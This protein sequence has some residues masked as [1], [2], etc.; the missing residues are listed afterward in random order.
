MAFSMIIYSFHLT[1]RS[2]IAFRKGYLQG[3][4]FVTSS[5]L[6]TVANIPGKSW[7]KVL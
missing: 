7:L 3:F 4:E 6:L 2:S 5:P 1:F